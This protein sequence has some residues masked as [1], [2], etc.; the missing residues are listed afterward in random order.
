MELDTRA[1]VTVIPDEIWQKDLGAVSVKKFNVP[2][3]SYSSHSILVIGKA[4][5]HVK[6]G[7]QEID[8]LIIVNEGNLVCARLG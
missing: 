1:A 2:L 5:V 7:D 8:L 4:A 6:Y 3:K